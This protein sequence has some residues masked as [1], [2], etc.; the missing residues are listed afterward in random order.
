M[1]DAQP[2][3]GDNNAISSALNTVSTVMTL[4][5]CAAAFSNKPAVA[6]KDMGMAVGVSAIN[7]FM[8]AIL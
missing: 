1:A 5:A 8:K 7:S 2:L 4:D 6:A 3:H